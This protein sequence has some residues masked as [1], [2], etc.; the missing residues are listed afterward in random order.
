M[1]VF[2]LFILNLVRIL[3]KVA[4]WYGNYVFYPS[5]TYGFTR[6]ML[7]Y[8]SFTRVLELGRDL[9]SRVLSFELW[10]KVSGMPYQFL[11]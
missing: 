6:S 10:H 7:I 1:S 11:I 2:W 4:F 5:R 9:G 8:L 3:E